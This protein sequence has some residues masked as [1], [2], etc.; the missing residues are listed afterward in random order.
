MT[1]ALARALAPEVPVNAV[2]PGFIDTRAGGKTHPL[3][4]DVKQ[5]SLE[6]SPLQRVC[7]PDDVAAVVVDLAAADLITGQVIVVTAA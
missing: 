5:F 1:I 4:G 2:A 7:R 3:Y 6:R